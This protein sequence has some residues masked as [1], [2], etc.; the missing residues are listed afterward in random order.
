[1]RDATEAGVKCMHS[2]Y[3]LYQNYSV[4]GPFLAW[5]PQI[6]YKPPIRVM[7]EI[8]RFMYSAQPHHP[9]TD[10]LL[11]Q[12]QFCLSLHVPPNNKNTAYS[13]VKKFSS[14]RPHWESRRQPTFRAP[15]ARAC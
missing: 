2:P 15:K 4:Q 14:R 10:I 8:I 11:E 7:P 13:A 6:N 3:N 12:L 9:T 5:I 1:M